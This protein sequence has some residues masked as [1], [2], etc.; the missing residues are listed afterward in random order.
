MGVCMV[1]QTKKTYHNFTIFNII[2]KLKIWG[3]NWKR[4]NSENMQLKVAHILIYHYVTKL[5]Q[6]I[7]M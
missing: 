1:Q 2:K 3:H 6:I 5:V 4:F 7:M